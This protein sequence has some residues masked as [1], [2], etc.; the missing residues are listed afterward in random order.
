MLFELN[1][2]IKIK[3]RTL[4]FSQVKKIGTFDE[5]DVYFNNWKCA[6]FKY[7]C[8]NTPKS[9]YSFEK[10]KSYLFIGK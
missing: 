6:D 10:K 8:V 4:D 7:V 5:I 3:N 9:T 2:F 1:D